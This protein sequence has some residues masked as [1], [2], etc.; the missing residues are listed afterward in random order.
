MQAM[1][2]LSKSSED[3]KTG[4]L[5]VTWKLCG[6]VEVFCVCAAAI[7]GQ[8]RKSS[9]SVSISGEILNVILSRFSR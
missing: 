7:F 4:S 5:V 2:N 8:Y 1:K 9:C 3:E 6:R